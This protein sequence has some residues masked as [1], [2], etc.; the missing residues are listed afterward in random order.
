[1]ANAFHPFL[2]FPLAL[3]LSLIFN[4]SSAAYNSTDLIQTTC[5][6]TNDYQLCISSL[7]SDPRS[8]TADLN[9]FAKI[10]IEL[11]LSNVT[12]TYS[13]IAKLI[14]D[15]EIDHV[16][17]ICLYDCSAVYDIGVNYLKD[18]LTYLDLKAYIE[19]A[20]LVG[21]AGGEGVEC[22]NMF[23]KP[24]VP[25]S[26]SPLTYRNEILE[27]LCSISKVIVSLLG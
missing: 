1:M 7:E 10:M 8:S 6:K 19:V 16:L 24:P 2:V 4:L 17:K 26:P 20:K 9:I 3:A 14:N 12:D 23:K 21:S 22:D 18:A 27:K 11:T 13:F 5:N 25:K 15:T